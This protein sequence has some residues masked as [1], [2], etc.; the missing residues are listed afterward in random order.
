MSIVCVMA[1]LLP[2]VLYLCYT[3]Y[4]PRVLSPCYF[5]LSNVVPQCMYTGPPV[6][7]VSAEFDSPSVVTCSRE[8]E[9]EFHI[10]IPLQANRCAKTRCQKAVG[11]VK[12]VAKEMLG[13]DL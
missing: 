8:R 13:V 3:L 4:F 10:Y 5:Y 11:G 12:T 1:V 6:L 7:S 2:P 9:R